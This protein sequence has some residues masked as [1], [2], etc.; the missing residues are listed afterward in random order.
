MAALNIANDAITGNTRMASMIR[1]EYDSELD[2]S[3][4]QKKLNKIHSQVEN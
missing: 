2:L 1:T 4:N 3:D